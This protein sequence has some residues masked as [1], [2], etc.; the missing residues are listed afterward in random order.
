MFRRLLEQSR[1]IGRAILGIT[2]G[3][4]GH[5]GRVWWSRAPV[6]RFH[7]ARPRRSW[8]S[9]PRSEG[10]P[11]AGIVADLADLCDC[12]GCGDHLWLNPR[13][14][15]LRVRQVPGR[16]GKLWEKQIPQHWRYG[17]MSESEIE[18]QMEK[19]KATVTSCRLSQD[20]FTDSVHLA[21]ALPRSFSCCGNQLVKAQSSFNAPP[22]EPGEVLPKPRQ[23]PLLTTETTSPPGS[24]RSKS[25]NRATAISLPVGGRVPSSRVRVAVQRFPLRCAFPDRRK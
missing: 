11:R 20:P 8:G 25:M 14:W 9:H 4:G 3:A 7:E 22:D 1:S 19:R 21:Q 23:V 15:N 18:K 13:L 6:P 17:N 12:G 24:W 16:E 5:G 2:I 10:R